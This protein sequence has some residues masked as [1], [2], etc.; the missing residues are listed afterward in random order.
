MK[1]SEHFFWILQSDIKKFTLTY[2]R[3]II[4]HIETS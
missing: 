4:P 2:E 1:F 3:P